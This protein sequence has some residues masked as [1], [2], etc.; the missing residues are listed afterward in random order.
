MIVNNSGNDP[1]NITSQL[2]QAFKERV[3]NIEKSIAL[4]NNAFERST[5]IK[6]KSLIAWSQ[7]HLG[8]FDMILSNHQSSLSH[9]Q[10]AINH[11]EKDNDRAGLALS[12]FTIGSINYKTDNYHL[13]LKFLSDSFQMYQDVDDKLGQSRTLKAIGS[14]YEFF[15]EYDKAEETYQK[16]IDIS[17]T[18]DDKNGVSNA[19]NPLS[20]I[21]IRKGQID[22]ALKIIKKSIRLKKITNDQRGLGFAYYGLGKVYLAQEKYD[23]AKKYLEKSLEIHATMNELVGSMMTLNKQGQMYYQTKAYDKAKKLLLSCIQKGK[24]SKHFLITHKS[25]WHLYKIAKKEKDHQSALEYLELHQSHKEKVINK[26]TKNVINSIQS[27]SRL[28]LLEKET[29]WQKEINSKVERKNKELDSFV[30]KVSHDLRGPISSLM[31][32]F[33]LVK[34]DVTDAKALEYFEIYNR[35]I[36]RLNGILMDFLNLIQIKEKEIQNE[37]IDFE[38]LV[39]N[40]LSSFEYHENFDKINFEIRIK[41]SISFCSDKS[42]ITSILQ[43]LL[44]NSIKYANTKNAAFVKINIHELGQGVSIKVT[45]NGLGIKKEH[46]KKIF[47]MF[48]R[49]H[50]KIKGTGLGLYIVKCAIDKLKGSIEVKSRINQGSTIQV[51]LPKV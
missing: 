36:N 50:Q 24:K 49:S 30:Y 22:Q 44:E 37:M 3:N 21:L 19:L 13:A 5:Q 43:N 7:A 29:K 47:D 48:F 42:T 12:Y 23:L 46:Q 20:G 2:E 34:Y 45:D 10:A 11:F 28:E 51:V 26:E 17:I 16:C 1:E 39:E 38:S 15:E 14:V 4:A 40:C 41:D 31:G 18:I 32:L 6:N 33:D 8:Y 9:T 35:Q 25:Y 27:I